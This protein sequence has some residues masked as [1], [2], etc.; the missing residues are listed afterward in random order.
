MALRIRMV[1]SSKGEELIRTLDRQV[2]DYTKDDP[3]VIE[4]HLWWVIYDGKTPIAYAGAK[5]LPH[6]KVVYLSRAGV[7]DGYRGKHLQRRLI[8]AR[9][10]WARKI[11]ATQAITYTVVTNPASS[12]NLIKCGFVTYIPAWKWGGRSAIYWVYNFD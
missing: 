4:G 2:F 6:E 1:L 11:G 9:V 10:R 3:V 5:Y 7:L 8:R 12:N